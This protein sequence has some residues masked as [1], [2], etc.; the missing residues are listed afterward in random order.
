MAF[1]DLQTGFYQQ[2]FAILQKTHPDLAA[3][4]HSL[5]PTSCYAWVETPAGC[6]TL[7]IN[8]GKSPVFLHSRHDP[9]REAQREIQTLTINSPSV[10]VFLGIGLGYTLEA[11]C[12]SSSPLITGLLL[13]ERNLDF[14]YHLLHRRDWTPILQ[15][16]C[17]RIV[18]PDRAVDIIP[19]IHSLLPQIMGSGLRFIDHRASNQIYA[20][21]YTGCVEC[22]RPFLQQAAA[23]SEFLVQFGRLIQRNAILNLPAMCASHGLGPLRD[24]F[25]NQPAVLAAAGP[26]LTH[27]LDELKPYRDH[28]LVFSVDTAY[29]VLQQH[30][31]MPDFVAATDA[32]ELNELHFKGIE[33]HPD[34]VLIFESDVYPSIPR[35]WAAPMIFVN[36][37]KAAINRWIEKIGGPF[38]CFEQGLSVA[39]TLFTAASWLGCNPIILI[40]HDF[41]YSKKGGKT[42]ANGTA[43]NRT[44]QKIAANDT[45]ATIEKS[46]FHPNPSKE[47]LTWVL[48]VRGD[49]VPTSKPLSVMLSKFAEL[50]HRSP[51]T[52]F[53]ATEDGAL[54]DGTI[55]TKFQS[56]LAS[57]DLHTPPSKI[58]KFLVDHQDP[59]DQSRVD[60]FQNVLDSLEIAKE[61]ARKGLALTQELIAYHG[62]STE[63]V[64]QNPNWKKIEDLFWE[65][66]RNPEIQ[67][68]L[69]QALFPSLFMFIKQETNE[70]TLNRLKKY[71]TV[72][73]SSLDLILEF[74]PYLK[75]SQSALSKCP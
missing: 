54:I 20:D 49:L 58:V 38:G 3:R 27:N 72:F 29:P 9:L 62:Q 25:K 36:S 51:Q 19:E 31:I 13:I 5:V 32:S 50:I 71:Q 46:V 10:F 61:N 35:S 34:V 21:F 59:Q 65:L 40:G 30:G 56:I 11:L 23:E 4:L 12:A 53:D 41:A 15:N 43:L 75:E 66:Y 45:E 64:N 44:I 28:L 55:P 48:G 67:I 74:I 1:S 17:T 70:S 22:L 24:Y 60:S 68:S 73:Q 69:E 2:N 63:P 52:V 8:C 7:E 14:F 39:H 37:E 16:P 18:I 42:H 57:L 47:K 26:S 33:S 6:P